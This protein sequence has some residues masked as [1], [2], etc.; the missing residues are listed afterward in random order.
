MSEQLYSVIMHTSL[1]KKHGT[2][3]ASV[4]GAILNG[5]LDILKHKEPFEGVIDNSG[6]C[7]II[8]KFTTLMRTVSFVASGTMTESF[9]KLKLYGDRNVFELSGTPCP[10]ERITEI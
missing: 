6:N 2:L 4:S 10:E 5:W 8:G 7:R 3:Y 9:V 1:G